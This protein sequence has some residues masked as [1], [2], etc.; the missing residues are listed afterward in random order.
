MPRCAMGRMEPIPNADEHD[1]PSDMRHHWA[2]L[3]PR[4]CSTE[5]SPESTVTRTQSEADMRNTTISGNHPAIGE[6]VWIAAGLIVLIAFGDALIVLGLALA[7]ALMTMAWWTYRQV[8]HRGELNDAQM[9]PVTHLRPASN[10]QRE[11]NKTSAHALWR[12]PRA[13]A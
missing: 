3:P 1:P 12:G 5:R 11:L 13:A 7:I 8:E 9:A 6:A 4:R 2:A 10:G